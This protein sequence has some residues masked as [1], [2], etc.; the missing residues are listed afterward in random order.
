MISTT[1]Y[2][3]STRR[4][5]GCSYTVALSSTCD[6]RA[7][8]CGRRW[9]LIAALPT[10]RHLPVG[11]ITT[12][13]ASDNATDDPIWNGN[14]LSARRSWRQ[15]NGYRRRL[16]R[17]SVSRRTGQSTPHRLSSPDAQRRSEQQF[18]VS[19]RPPAA[20]TVTAHWQRM[21]FDV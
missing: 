5:Q 6:V 10:L 18:S 19:S 7:A 14:A 21:Y 17:R 3:L 9:F 1:I 12:R 2:L 4:C 11:L 8:P 13:L 20:P 15:R 16:S